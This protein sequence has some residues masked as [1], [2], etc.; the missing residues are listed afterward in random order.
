MDKPIFKLLS[1]F[2]DKTERIVGEKRFFVKNSKGKEIRVKSEEDSDYSR[3]CTHDDNG[4][5]IVNF[6][7][8]KS[9][10]EQYIDYLEEEIIGKD[11]K[12]AY[13][14]IYLDQNFKKEYLE[15]K[16]ICRANKWNIEEKFPSITKHWQKKQYKNAK[17]IRNYLEEVR[18]EIYGNC[19][20]PYRNDDNPNEIYY[21]AK[22]IYDKI[23]FLLIK[24]AK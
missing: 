13:E 18:R 24:C 7:I 20:F 17:Y 19:I 12:L 22:E 6:K 15:L 2:S 23:Y 3:I 1:N 16:E 9:R 4:K 21:R 11:P 8:V 14:N 5:E 10:L